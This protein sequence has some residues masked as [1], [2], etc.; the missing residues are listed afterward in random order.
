[1]EHEVGEGLTAMRGTVHSWNGSGWLT[2]ACA[3]PR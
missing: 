1:M 2:A 3:G